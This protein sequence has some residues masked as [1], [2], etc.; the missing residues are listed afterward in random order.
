MR[1]ILSYTL[2][3]MHVFFHDAKNR[4]VIIALNSY[5]TAAYPQ[6]SKVPFKLFQSKMNTSETDLTLP[7]LGVSN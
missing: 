3:R 6:I 5:L 4:Q 1:Q 7:I 2:M